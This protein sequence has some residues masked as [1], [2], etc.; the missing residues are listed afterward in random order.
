MKK[1]YLFVIFITLSQFSFGQLNSYPINYQVLY[2]YTYQTD[3]LNIESKKEELMELLVAQAGETF[4]QSYNK[5]V[6]DSIVM[7]D[8]IDRNRGIDMKVQSK[9]KHNIYS[10]IFQT[11][12]NFITRDTYINSLGRE[13]DY[14]YYRENMGLNWQLQEQIDS[15]NGIPVQKATCRL[16]NHGWTAWFAPGI[17]L[18]YGPYKFSGLP[19]L[20]L[21]MEDD[22]GYF[23]F[24]MVAINNK[25]NRSI[26]F[27]NEEYLVKKQIT[28]TQYL[29]EKY[30]Y[31]EN[32]TIIEIQSKEIFFTNEDAKRKEIIRDKERLSKYN[33]WI[34]RFL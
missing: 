19:G 8:D 1:I 20:I 18:P 21:K 12:Q 29:K 3:S 23:S 11:N 2:K 9:T 14:S 16:G 7:A 22:S 24:E 10:T 28:K 26:H 27:P 34:E 13:K 4:Y 6:R 5:G 32:R 25:I 31:L 30:Y 17:N 15:I 33:I